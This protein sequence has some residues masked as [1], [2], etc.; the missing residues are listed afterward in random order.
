[1]RSYRE[2]LKEAVALLLTSAIHISFA[3]IVHDGPWTNNDWVNPVYGIGVSN[4]KMYGSDS[5]ITH[6]RIRDAWMQPAHA[7]LA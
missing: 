2:L 1:M 7:Y 3:F 4:G 6:A 5:I